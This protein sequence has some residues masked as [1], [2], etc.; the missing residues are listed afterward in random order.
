[1]RF[2][3]SS[4]FPNRPASFALSVA[5]MTLLTAC[6]PI[7]VT[8]TGTTPIPWPSDGRGE[9]PQPPVVRRSEGVIKKGDTA[10]ASGTDVY[11]CADKECKTARKADSKQ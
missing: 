2:K 10:G 11:V 5:V 8:T 6:S 7:P 4:R 3:V 9:G 1:M